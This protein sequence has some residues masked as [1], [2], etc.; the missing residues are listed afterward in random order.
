MCTSVFFC[1]QTCLNS[2]NVTYTSV[3]RKPGEEIYFWKVH[4]K[5]SVSFLWFYKNNFT[6]TLL[7][8]NIRFIY[9]W[10]EHTNIFIHFRNPPELVF[11]FTLNKPIQSKIKEINTILS[12]QPTEHW[13][14]RCMTI[15]KHQKPCCAE[16]KSGKDNQ[17]S[18]WELD[19][20]HV[21]LNFNFTP[22]CKSTGAE[23]TSQADGYTAEV[24]AS[25]CLMCI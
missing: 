2:L 11:S 16:E 20:F 15:G 4:K 19:R 22:C 6:F 1:V 3:F 10:I 24:Q 17:N 14:N 5:W 25:S 9:K 18:M 12:H 13:Y 23:L 21:T 8:L 7:I